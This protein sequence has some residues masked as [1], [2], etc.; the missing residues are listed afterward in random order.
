MARTSGPCETL[1]EFEVEE[2]ACDVLSPA[3]DPRTIDCF[4][5]SI[6]SVGVMLDA[7]TIG[8][9]RQGRLTEEEST[10]S[11]SGLI[12]EAH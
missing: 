7:S 12:I 3:E 8:F 10:S 1:L 5:M 9:G 11:A 6:T 2:D 4:F